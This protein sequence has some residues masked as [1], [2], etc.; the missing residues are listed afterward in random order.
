MEQWGL[1]PAAGAALAARV[2]SCGPL[3]GAEGEPAGPLRVSAGALRKWLECQIQGGALLRL[4]LRAEDEYDPAERAEEPFATAFLDRWSVLRGALWEALASGRPATAVLRERLARMREEAKAPAGFL[5]AGERAAAARQLTGWEG[6]MPPGAAPVLYRFGAERGRIRPALPVQ[7]CAPL[8]LD[9]DLGGAPVRCQLEGLTEPQGDGATLMLSER[10]LAALGK[11]PTLKDRC[12]LLRAW[13]DQLLLAAAGIREGGHR[14]RVFA[15]YQGASQVREVQL[16]PVTRDEARARLG[17]WI[18]EAFGRP[19][20][21]LMPIEAVLDLWSQ[22]G[23]AGPAALAEWI[24]QAGD[25][26]FSSLYGP[27]PRALGAPLEADW[28]GL[29][30]ARLGTFPDWSARWE[31]AP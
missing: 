31:S 20:W 23:Q 25:G 22:E 1:D 30:A 2:H 13:F 19:R 3:A 15:W 24:E 11:P 14:A 9:L 12:A 28:R 4:G 6:L 18:E 29:A 10:P 17:A 16:P 7:A 8:E 26:G 27:L 5:G 21:T